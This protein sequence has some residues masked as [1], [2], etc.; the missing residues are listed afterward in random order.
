[1]KQPLLPTWM[2]V[3]TVVTVLAAGWLTLQLPET[4]ETTDA[5]ALWWSDTT[6]IGAMGLAV[7][8]GAWVIWDGRR[9]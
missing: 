4:A 8:V 6:V 7:I 5:T 3:V 1:M 2:V 9:R